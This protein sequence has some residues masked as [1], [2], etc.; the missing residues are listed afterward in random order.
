MLAAVGPDWIIC[1]GCGWRLGER[2]DGLALVH[3]AGRTLLAVYVACHR[4]RCRGSWTSAKYRAV[5]DHARGLKR[6]S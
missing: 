3:H 5:L 4:P 6:V 2:V 1:P